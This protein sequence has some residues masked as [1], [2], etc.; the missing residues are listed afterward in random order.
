MFS[1]WW[2]KSFSTDNGCAIYLILKLTIYMNTQTNTVTWHSQLFRDS[3]LRRINKSR[4]KQRVL[5]ILRGIKW[6]SNMIRENWF[7]KKTASLNNIICVDFVNI[8]FKIT[9]KN[10]RKDTALSQLISI[11]TLAK[12]VKIMLHNIKSNCFLKKPGSG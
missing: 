9:W 11:D 4:I 8:S 12:S 2:M 1:L 7:I 10:A 5:C 3:T 6:R